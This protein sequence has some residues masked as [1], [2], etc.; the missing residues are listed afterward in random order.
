[1]QISFSTRAGSRRANED[2]VVCGPDWAVV[3]DGATPVPGTDSGCR[4]GVPW[5]VHRLAAALAGRLTLGGPGSLAATLAAA[6]GEVRDA[7]AGTCD[8]ANPDTPSSTAALA[9]V[10][11]GVLEYLVLCD[12]PIVL[13]RADGGIELI[14]DDRL[15][16][17]PGGRPYPPGLV[18]AHRNRPGGFWVAST[19]PAAA[20][21]A[22]T[23]STDLA[24][25]KDAALVTDGVTRLADWYGYG[26][27][28]ILATLAGQGPDALLDLVRA[29]ERAD[30]R[31]RVKRHDDATVAHLHW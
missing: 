23:G 18:R 15:A 2:H 20:D 28:E 1:V 22:V 27:T 10:R 29:A 7:H 31:P 24:T 21:Q 25:V 6:I 16:R 26:W 13:R 12:S 4:H 9:R 19:D 8:L 3:L 17:L 5:L 14:A 11:G 30:P